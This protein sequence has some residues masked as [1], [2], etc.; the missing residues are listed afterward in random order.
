MSVIIPG[1]NKNHQRVKIATTNNYN[2][3]LGNNQIKVNYNF[4]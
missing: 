3:L 2:S 4:V 1:M